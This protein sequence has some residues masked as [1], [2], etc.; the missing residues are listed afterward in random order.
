MHTDFT[1]CR[2]CGEKYELGVTYLKELMLGDRFQVCTTHDGVGHC[3]IANKCIFELRE[4]EINTI[5][6]WDG[7]S[8][9]NL[10]PLLSVKRV[11]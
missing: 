5:S 9:R 2:V 4:F 8:Y 11:D 6:C 3:K 7:S 1:H 10:S